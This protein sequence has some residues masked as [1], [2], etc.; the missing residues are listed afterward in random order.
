VRPLAGRY[1]LEHLIGEGSFASVHAAWD[2]QA[3]RRVAIKVLKDTTRQRPRMIERF[4]REGRTLADLAHPH[5]VQVLDVGCEQ[6]RDYLVL[7]FVD[8]ESLGERLEGRRPMSQDQVVEL[9]LQLL[10]GLAA[11]HAEGIVHRDVKPPNVLL[12]GDQAVLGDFGIA[13]P[14][15]GDGSGRITRTGA[16]L[17]TFGYMAPEQLVDAKNVGVQADLYGLG[18]TLYHAC[19]GYAPANL[20][21]AALD[22]PRWRRVPP[23]LVPVLSR[24]VRLDPAERWADA[25]AMGRALLSCRG[26]PELPAALDPTRWPAPHADLTLE[27]APACVPFE[28]PSGPNRDTLWDLPTNHEEQPVERRRWPWLAAGVALVMAGLWWW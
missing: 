4:R 14:M 22:S 17:G 27:A 11:A 7:S 24:A 3:E 23:E 10:A 15:A 13:A 8:G 1:R 21:A 28:P 9:G 25:G 2:L 6:G 20:H 12:S 26:R 18:A 19:S 16:T 5:L